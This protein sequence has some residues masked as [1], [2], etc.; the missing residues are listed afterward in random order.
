MSAI[1]DNFFADMAEIT[2]GFGQP[3]PKKR[4]ALSATITVKGIEV[5]VTFDMEG[6]HLRATETDPAEE[7]FPVLVTAHV[8][9]ADITAWD[10]HLGI[11][12]ELDDLHAR[13]GL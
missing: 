13:G 11:S 8:D 12:N 4:G 2:R 10:E 7:P 5:D 9:C 3:K 6:T 1:T